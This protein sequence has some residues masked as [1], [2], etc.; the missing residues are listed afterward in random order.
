MAALIPLVLCRTDIR[1]DFRDLNPE[2]FIQS[3]VCTFTLKA[4]DYLVVPLFLSPSDN[5][6]L[7]FGASSLAFLGRNRIILRI[8]RVQSF[9]H[10]AQKASGSRVHL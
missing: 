7:S 1:L 3:D 2:L 9:P 8:A 5:C 4:N 10:L 6:A